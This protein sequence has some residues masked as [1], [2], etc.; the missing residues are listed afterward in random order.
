MA[1]VAQSDLSPSPI[2]MGLY[3]LII[4]KHKHQVFLLNKLMSSAE[5]FTRNAIA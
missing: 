4:L 1:P 5:P 2:Y 3:L